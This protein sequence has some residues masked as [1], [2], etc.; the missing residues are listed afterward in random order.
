MAEDRIRVLIAEDHNLVREGTRQILTAAGDID[1]V[2]EADRGDTAVRLAEELAPDVAILDVRL[3]GMN[4]IEATRRLR[5]LE[6]PVRVLILSAYDDDQY[7][8]EALRAGASG[9]LL[10]TARGRELISAVRMV[11][12]GASVL[13]PAIST[14]LAGGGG[15][16]SGVQRLSPRELEVVRLI[17]DGLHNKEIAGALGISRRTVEGHLNNVFAKLGVASR[18]EVVLAALSRRL[19]ILAPTEP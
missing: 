15:G 19:V 10:K 16:A 17:A 14:R 6:P 4:G 7:V 18:T 1:I 9:Y 11:A 3:P 12:E 5:R 2:G 8:L 13:E